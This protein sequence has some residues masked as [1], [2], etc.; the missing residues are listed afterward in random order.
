MA[1]RTRENAPKK[2]SEDPETLRAADPA[3]LPVSER[4]R[5]APGGTGGRASRQERQDPVDRASDESFP[6]SDPPAH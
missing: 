5:R 1:G 4:P 2:L 6:A 3:A